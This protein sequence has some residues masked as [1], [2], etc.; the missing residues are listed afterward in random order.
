MNNQN[1]LLED[2]AVFEIQSIVFWMSSSVRMTQVVD[3]I[4]NICTQR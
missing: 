2:I 4:V 3:N 1:Y